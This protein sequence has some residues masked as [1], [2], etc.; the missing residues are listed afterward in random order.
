MHWRDLISLIMLT[1]HLALQDLLR[2]C[3][4]APHPPSRRLALALSVFP[5][6]GEEVENLMTSL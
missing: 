3:V 5:M 1:L 2:W 6:Q 4:L